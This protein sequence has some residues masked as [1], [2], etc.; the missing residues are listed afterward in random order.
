MAKTIGI[1]G[2]GLIGASIGLALRRRPEEYEVLGWDIKRENAERA[3]QL[4]AI[5]EAVTD[6]EFATRFAAARIT[7]VATPPAAIAANVAKAAAAVAKGGLIT[8]T[9][10]VKREVLRAVGTALPPS[11]HF[12]GS[13]PIAGTEHSGPD[14]AAGDLF[15]GR[16][17]V[18]TP[19][20]QT[21]KGKLADLKALW[22]AVGMRVL[23]MSAERHDKT[24]ALTSHL[25]HLIAY[26]LTNQVLRAENKEEKDHL[27]EIARLSAGGL[28]DFTRIA[29]SDARMWRDIFAANSVEI[30]A[31]LKG[32]EESI[33]ELGCLIAEGDKEVITEYLRRAKR[34][35][36]RVVAERQH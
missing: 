34:M 8:D 32:F 9:G 29:A 1:I 15:V 22:R 17:C 28:R 19:H 5:D 2:T 35:Q 20:A 23:R 3:R 10:S 25:P 18:V 16:W 4:G 11:V 31:A 24:L 33:R 36:R 6:A 7:V 26:A 12:I 14:A 30:A 27:G 21:P 13:H